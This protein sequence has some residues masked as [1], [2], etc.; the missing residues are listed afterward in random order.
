MFER[1]V[2]RFLVSY[3]YYYGA[4]YNRKG[5]IFQK[6]FKHMEINDESYLQQAIIYVNANAQKHKLVNAFKTWPWN[7]YTAC[8][9]SDPSYVNIEQVLKFFGSR[10][11]F[12]DAHTAQVA[13]YYSNAWPNSK[14]E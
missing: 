2:N 3:A 9:N 7:A 14:L 12:I 5:G 4:K 1:Q 6:P 10:Q 13:N 11:Q 8:I